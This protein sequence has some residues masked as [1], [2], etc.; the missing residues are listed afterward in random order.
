MRTLREVTQAALELSEED[1]AMLAD[2]LAES[3][4]PA[5]WEEAWRKEIERRS[6]QLEDGTVQGIPWAEVK[7]AGRQRMKK[8][9]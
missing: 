1:R 4:S 8:N 7:E 3:L 5:S 2:T 9:A 6:R